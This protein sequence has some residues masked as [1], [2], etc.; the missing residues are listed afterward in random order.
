MLTGPTGIAADE[1][2]YT[3]RSLINQARMIAEASS[4]VASK[5]GGPCLPVGPFPSSRDASGSARQ[6]WLLADG[7]SNQPD[8]N[9]LTS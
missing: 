9:L 7:H 1:T 3:N 2:A 5:T 4:T 6:S 8:G